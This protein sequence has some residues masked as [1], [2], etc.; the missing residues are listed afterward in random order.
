MAEVSY[1]ISRVESFKDDCHV[2][3]WAAMANGDHGTAISMAG[4]ADKSIQ[5]LGT[6][7]VGGNAQV[8]GSNVVSPT[9]TFASTDFVTLTDPQGNA[10][11]INSL[12]V[13]MIT[14]NTLFVRPK[15]TAGDGTTSITVRMLV[16]RA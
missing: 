11:D 13:E 9:T 4:S 14:E 3:T 5:V 16:R 6:L 12:K 8:Q 2:V 15:I 7:G 10:L 1:T